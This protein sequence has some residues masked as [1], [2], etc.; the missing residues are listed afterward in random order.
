MKIAF[1]GYGNMAEALAV[2]WKSKHEL[3]VGGRNPDKAK[4]LAEQLGNNCRHGDSNDAVAFGDVVVLATPHDAVFETIQSCGGADAFAGKIVIDINNPVA[5]VTANDFTTKSYPEGSLAEAIAAKIPDAHVV[6][7]FNMC[8]AEV[9]KRDGQWD[10]RELVVLFCGDDANAK[11]AMSG[12]IE[13]LSFEPLD[14][15]EL[16]YARLLEPAAC[17]VIKLLFSGRDPMTVLNL[18]QPERKPIA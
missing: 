10:G 1:I 5:D 15:G 2:K 4:A 7:A 3:F 6:K 9:W 12:L 17:I 14:L 18:I 8:Q 13:D 16:K 11:H